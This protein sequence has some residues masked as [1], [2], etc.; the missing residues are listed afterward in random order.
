MDHLV[1]IVGLITALLGGSQAAIST[2]ANIQPNIGYQNNKFGLYIYSLNDYADAAAQLV[3][4][5]G[6]DWGYALVPYAVYD[7]DFEKWDGFF[8]QLNHDHLIPII[9]LWDL[10]SPTD[11]KHAA[12]FLDSLP[13][14]ILKHYV[15]V[16]NE[17]N[18]GAFWNGKAD[19]ESYAHV[20]DETINTFKAQNQ[21][22]FMLNG[23][24]NASARTGG[25][26]IDEE[27]FLLRMDKE[28]PGIFKKLDGWASHSYP[29]P[30]FT[31]AV[32]DT[33]RDSI[34]AYDW[35]LGLLDKYFGINTLPVFI[36]ETGWAH[37][38]GQVF[39]PAYY[40]AT[41]TAGYFKAAFESVW[42]PDSRVV[43]VTPFTIKYNTP[44]DHFN[45]LDSNLKPFPQ[46]DTVA[47]MPKTTGLPPLSPWYTFL[48][49]MEAKVRLMFEASSSGY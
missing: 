36:T 41:A 10:R 15:S 47:A 13:W 39:N 24:F 6:G 28:K 40:S 48:P 32:T 38:E 7:N 9:Q 18:D 35:E 22:F 3:N 1:V 26:Y 45:W 29:Q 23:A 5:N 37:Q 33:G 46:Y 20:L 21:Q 8:R 42:L 4:T 16:Y 19:P 11:T 12:Q 34:K 49:N 17:P 31:G 44:N 14:P 2:K 30:N 27:Q 43:A 25:N